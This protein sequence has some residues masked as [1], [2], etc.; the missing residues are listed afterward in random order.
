MVREI[1][2]NEILSESC[3]VTQAI[4]FTYLTEQCILSKELL[5]RH[6][7]F[8]KFSDQFKM[9]Y[10]TIGNETKHPLQLLAYQL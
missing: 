8:L 7:I 9:Q 10:Q 1:V 4:T 3:S 5:R 2:P 6:C